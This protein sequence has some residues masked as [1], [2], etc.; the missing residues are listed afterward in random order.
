MKSFNIGGATV[1]TFTGETNNGYRKVLID[2]QD[3][4]PTRVDWQPRKSAT[5]RRE[6]MA[7]ARKHTPGGFAGV[8]IEINIETYSNIDLWD[9]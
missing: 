4:S 1:V 6:A 2:I 5:T 8:L 9:E 3:G 7:F